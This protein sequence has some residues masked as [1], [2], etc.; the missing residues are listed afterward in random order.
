METINEIPV[1]TVEDVET[2][3]KKFSGAIDSANIYYKETTSTTESK[4]SIM[5][6]RKNDLQN[7]VVEFLKSYN[8]NIKFDVNQEVIGIGGKRKHYD[9]AEKT[10][11][12]LSKIIKKCHETI[13]PDEYIPNA[14]LFVQNTLNVFTG[15]NISDLVDSYSPNQDGKKENGLL[16]ELSDLISL[17]CTPKGEN[18]NQSENPMQKVIRFLLGP[19]FQQI[20]KHKEILLS[21]EMKSQESYCKFL[22][23]LF[24]YALDTA[25]ADANNLDTYIQKEII[26][27][28]KSGQTEQVEEDNKGNGIIT[29][30]YLENLARVTYQRTPKNALKILKDKFGTVIGADYDRNLNKKERSLVIVARNGNGVKQ[31]HNFHFPKQTRGYVNDLLYDLIIEAQRKQQI[32]SGWTTQTSNAARA[33]KKGY[34]SD[35]AK[36]G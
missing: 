17:K 35:N 14:H 16:S 21:T 23:N 1:N 24:A 27:L 15:L 10:Y 29:V 6:I 32:S 13:D 26:E 31:T 30:E 22:K 11:R 25:P 33:L 9:L 3:I 12:L 28:S 2:R 36:L 34:L 19:G 20:L 18:P 5:Q 4:D 8:V 7:Y